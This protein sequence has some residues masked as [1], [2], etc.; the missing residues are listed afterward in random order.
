L[1]GENRKFQDLGGGKRKGYKISL[2]PQEEKKRRGLRHCKAFLHREG[3]T[4]GNRLFSPDKQKG[5]SN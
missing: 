3:G 4:V 1:E 2:K 5:V